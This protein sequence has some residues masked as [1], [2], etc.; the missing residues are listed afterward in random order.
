MARS[1]VLARLAVLVVAAILV[2]QMAAFV[3]LPSQVTAT[4][5][6]GMAAGIVS[7]VAAAQ[8]AWATDGSA[9]DSWGAP[10]L[11]AVAIPIIGICFL[12]LDWES[13]Q[14]PVDDVTGYGTLGVQVD[15]P[16]PDEPAYFRR[17]PE[18]G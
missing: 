3:A 5:Q 9:F 16:T 7:A 10:E 15:G 4:L 14:A 1:T 12:Y 17:S 8:P 11:T 6:S 2:G 13:K 18:S